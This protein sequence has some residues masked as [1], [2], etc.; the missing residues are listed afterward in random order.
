MTKLGVL[1]SPHLAGSRV[2]VH[3]QE[4]NFSVKLFLELLKQTI[5][6]TEDQITV[7]RSISETFPVLL[8]RGESGRAVPGRH[9]VVKANITALSERALLGLHAWKPFKAPSGAFGCVPS[10]QEAMD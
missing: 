4:I 10:E 5:W 8:G 3:N 1:N 7:G 2:P 9:L 6:S